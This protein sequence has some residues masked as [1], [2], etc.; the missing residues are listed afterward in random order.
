MPKSSLKARLRSGDFGGASCGARAFGLV[1][2]LVCG[3]LLTACYPPAGGDL[4]PIAGRDGATLLTTRFK[5]DTLNIAQSG[6]TM[7]ARGRWS[8]ADSSTS[9][10]LDVSNANAQ[11]VTVDFGRAELTNNSSRQQLRLR[12]V[13]DERAAGGPSFLDER[14]LTIDGGQ[15]KSFVLEFKVDSPD[16]RSGVARD[17]Q[18]QTVTLRVPV[19]FQTEAAAQVDF[20]LEFRYGGRMR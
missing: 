3:L 15:Q 20:I 8:V 18:G 11:A 6:V 5:D 17:V 16:G 1:L 9:V 14:V 2:T 10:I 19:R 7:K 4:A 12:S 13:S